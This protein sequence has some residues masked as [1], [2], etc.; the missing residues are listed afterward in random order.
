MRGGALKKTNSKSWCHIVC[1]L[2]NDEIQFTGNSLQNPISL[3]HISDQRKKLVGFVKFSSV[4]CA[5][6]CPDRRETHC[7]LFLY[8]LRCITFCSCSVQKCALCSGFHQ[9]AETSGGFV[10]CSARKCRTVFHVTCAVAA[11]VAFHW[12]STYFYIKCF[13]HVSKKL[14]VKVINLRI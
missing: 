5:F 10:V 4:S 3:D 1:A 14:D 2:P 8:C 12:S 6:D 7:H 11:G 9:S 13:K